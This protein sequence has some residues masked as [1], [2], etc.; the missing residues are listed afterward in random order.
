MRGIEIALWCIAFG[1]TGPFMLP[2]L[3]YRIIVLRR[4][5]RLPRQT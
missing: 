2:P 5:H 1:L 3:I 4:S